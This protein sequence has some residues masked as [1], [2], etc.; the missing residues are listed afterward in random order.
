MNDDELAVFLKAVDMAEQYNNRLRQAYTSIDER[1][2][3]LTGE[4]QKGANEVN[5]WSEL[6]FLRDLLTRMDN[7]S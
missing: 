4:I 5:I 7:K 3:Y 6:Q 1:L 2:E